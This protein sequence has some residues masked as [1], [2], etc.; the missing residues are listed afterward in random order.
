MALQVAL[1]YSYPDSSNPSYT[2]CLIRQINSAIVAFAAFYKASLTCT[3]PQLKNSER[4]NLNV[5]P[6]LMPH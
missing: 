5:I 4:K 3:I 2:N 1:Q 6:R